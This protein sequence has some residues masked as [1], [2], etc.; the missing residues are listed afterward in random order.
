MTT[1]SAKLLT[2]PSPG[3]YY[4]HYSFN[5]YLPDQTVKMFTFLPPNYPRINRNLVIIYPF[6]YVIPKI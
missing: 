1:E 4:C 5:T 2:V 3:S 6:K